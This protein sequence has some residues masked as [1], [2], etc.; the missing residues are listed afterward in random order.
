[1]IFFGAKFK[2]EIKET[3]IMSD[4]ECRIMRDTQL[5][6]GKPMDCDNI[7]CHR[8]ETAELEYLWL[9]ERVCMTL[10]C[11]LSHKFVNEKSK[12]GKLFKFEE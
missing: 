12:K 4:R 3:L 10:Q 2:E 6:D 9:R 8:L 7:G 5:C 11:E 1:M